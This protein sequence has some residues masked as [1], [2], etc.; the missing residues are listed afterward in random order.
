MKYCV[1]L[2]HNN[3]GSIRNNFYILGTTNKMAV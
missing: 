2:D 1:E 3:A